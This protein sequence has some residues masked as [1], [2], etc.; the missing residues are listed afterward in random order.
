MKPQAMFLRLARLLCPIIAIVSGGVWAGTQYLRERGAEQEQRQ[1]RRQVEVL[2]STI[3]NMKSQPDLGKVAAISKYPNEQVSFLDWLRATAA[4]TNVNLRRWSVVA[5]TPQ[6]SGKEQ[7]SGKPAE[8]QRPAGLETVASQVE[9]VG[10]F[11]SVRAFS[12]AVLR[13]P[14]LLSMSKIKLERADPP[15]Y[16]LLSCTLTRYVTA[17]QSGQAGGDSTRSAGPFGGIP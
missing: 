12:E 14:R 3:E 6:Q 11:K 17:S 16:T 15:P 4:A 5:P 7:Q 13:A 10:S 8:P 2:A 1:A 9:V